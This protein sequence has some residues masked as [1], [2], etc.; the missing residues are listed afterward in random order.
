[1]TTT[2]IIEARRAVLSLAAQAAC[3]PRTADRAI[4]RGARAVR[5]LAVRDR[6]ERAAQMLGIPLPDAKPA[7]RNP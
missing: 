3:D 4:R 2:E 6:I 1:M 7:E 5:P